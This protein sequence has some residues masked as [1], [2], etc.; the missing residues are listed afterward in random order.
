MLAKWGSTWLTAVTTS[1]NP[2]HRATDIALSSAVDLSWIQNLASIGDSY[3]A[4]LGSGKRVDFACSRYNA[5]YPSIV[6]E[7]LHARNTDS[8]HQFLACSGADTAEILAKQ[9]PALHTNLDLITISAGGNDIGLTPIL[10]NCVYQFYMA[11]EDACQKSVGEAQEKI[12]NDTQL[13]QNVTRLIEATKP[14]LNS[15]HGLIHVT[16]YARFFGTGDDSCDNVTWAVW[17]NVERH[18]Q[19]LKLEMRQALNNMVL[20]VNAVLRR[21]TE[22]AGP[23]VH[24]IDYDAR[25]AALQGRYCELGVHEPDPNRRALVLYEWDT[26]DRGEN[27]TGL[28]NST[29][30]AVPRGSFEGGIAEQINKTL[31]E[32]PEWRF[33]ADKGFVDGN[34]T[35][36]DGEGIIED[37]IHW[38]IPDSHKRVFHMR[39][40]GH[41]VV[42]SL[43]LED[44]RAYTMSRVQLAEMDEL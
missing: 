4:G 39:P 43:I 8:T 12:G 41:A 10:S 5:A 7:S 1:T 33:D 15:T 40:E 16:G 31:H 14:Y 20:S 34:G 28:Q 9:V 30:D 17:R 42:A 3:A 29:G 2:L 18:K 44:L 38:L 11:G 27:K 25:I 13:Y 24:F 36:V 23:N 35:L 21:A 37:T 32:H 6:H 19:Y 26:V 22:A